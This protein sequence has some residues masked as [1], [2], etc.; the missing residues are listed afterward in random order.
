MKDVKLSGNGSLLMA[1]SG[2]PTPK[3]FSREGR[4]VVRLIRGDMYLRDLSHTEGHV[5]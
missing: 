4:E 1:V 5:R 3:V 2:S